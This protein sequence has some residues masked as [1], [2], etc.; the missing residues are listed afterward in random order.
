[1][2]EPYPSSSS[3]I[4]LVPNPTLDAPRPPPPPPG[5]IEDLISLRIS[6]P[7]APGLTNQVNF[8]IFENCYVG[9]KCR[10]CRRPDVGSSSSAPGYHRRRA[11]NIGHDRSALAWVLQQP[12][13]TSL[14]PSLGK[15][16]C[17]STSTV[18]ELVIK[19]TQSLSQGG[20]TPAF[21][22]GS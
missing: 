7:H 9:Y 10:V 15:C 2:T 13:L 5:A 16:P 3:S 21:Q 17:T 18:P 11:R 6:V 8:F 14:A 12:Q 4:L 22:K 1:M 19:T 20:L